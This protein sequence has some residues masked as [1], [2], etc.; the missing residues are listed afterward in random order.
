MNVV[1]LRLPANQTRGGFARSGLGRFLTAMLKHIRP[2]DG[3][4]QIDLRD[5]PAT[6]AVATPARVKAPVFSIVERAKESQYERESR[7]E[8]DRQRRRLQASLQLQKTVQ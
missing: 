1:K 5:D 7:R 8:W 6:V 3:V 2:M 4:E